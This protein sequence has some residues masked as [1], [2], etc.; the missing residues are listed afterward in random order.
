MRTADCGLLLD[1]HNVFTNALNGR[2]P[3]DEFLEAAPLDRVWAMHLAGGMELDGFWL[4]AH[5]GAIPDALLAICE[6]VVPRLPNLAAIAF[7]IFPS[8]CLPSGTQSGSRRW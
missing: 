7:E 6:T 4:D 2:Q 5:S 3:L 1:M 8:S